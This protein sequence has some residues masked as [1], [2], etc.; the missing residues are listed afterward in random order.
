MEIFIF[1][2]PQICF[3]GTGQQSE[4]AGRGIHH[5]VQQIPHLT[6]DQQQFPAAAGKEILPAG[7]LSKFAGQAQQ[8]AVF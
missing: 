6:V 4:T 3:R 5:A 8:I 1:A 7:P 2:I